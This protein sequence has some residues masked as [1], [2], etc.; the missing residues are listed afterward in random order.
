MENPGIEQ[1]APPKTP[2]QALSLSEI[3]PRLKELLETGDTRAT[4][5]VD[6]ALT[7]AVH[8]GASDVHFEPWTDSLAVRFRIDGILHDIAHIPD[9]HKAR[10]TARIKVMAQMVVYQKDQPQDGRIPP[11]QT[12]S[13]YSMRV[14]TFPTINGEKI[15]VRILGTSKQM[16]E[17]DDLGFEA[18]VAETLRSL[19]RRPQGVILLTGPSSSGKT[20]TIFALLRELLRTQI[21]TTHIVTIEDPVEYRLDRV[22]QIQVNPRTGVTFQ[23]ALRSILRQ[24]PE[25]IMVGEIRDAETAKMAVQAGLTGH[26]VISTIHSGTASGVF[27]R[28]LDMGIEPYLL[29]SSVT[30]VLAQ[31]LARVNCPN[32]LETY[33]PT[34][35]LL[36]RF[37]KPPKNQPYKR[38][39]GCAQCQHIGY[40]GR[41][42]LGE[43]LLV[44]QDIANLILQRPTTNAMQEAA[45][46]H[47]M[48][49]LFRVGLE[50]AYKGITTPEEL[51]RVLPPPEVV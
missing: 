30:G 11:N 2:Q 47:H 17:V 5:A 36:T 41:T 20:T 22:T 35:D 19:V 14:A 21:A 42:A 46:A 26:L 8:H 1:E 40:R 39:K 33:T 9:S 50:A 7:Q 6:L 24:D 3:Q 32:C 44:N 51:S 27:A 49:S 4:L 13:G 48:R 12:S 16:L 45:A 15:V 18:S 34:P 38:G 43:L 10:I 23:N 28:L 29:A 37:G 31:R 25:V